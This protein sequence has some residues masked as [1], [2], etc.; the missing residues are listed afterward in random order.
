MAFSIRSTITAAMSRSVFRNAVWLFG[1]TVVTSGVGFL[2]WVLVARIAPQKSVGL[3]SAAISAMSLLANIGLLGLGNLMIG[4]LA[5]GRFQKGLVAASMAAAGGLSFILS[6]GYVLLRPLLGTRLGP[7]GHG[8]LGPLLFAAGTGVTCITYV[9]DSSAVGIDRGRVQFSR[10]VVFS[11]AKL[12]VVALGAAL[13]TG[14]LSPVIYGSWLVANLISL[15]AFLI[16]IR[17]AGVTPSLKPAFGALYQLRNSAFAHHWLNLSGQLPTMLITVVMSAVLVPRINATFYVTLIVI[18]SVGIIPMHFSTALFALPRGSMDR[19]AVEMRS[20]LRVSLALSGAGALVFLVGS[21]WILLLFGRGYLP[22]ETAMMVMGFY[23][24]PFTI[25]CHYAAVTRIRGQ[26]I[27]GSWV[28]M[29][30]GTLE[31]VLAYVGAKTDSITGAGVGFTSAITVEGLVLWP[32]VARAAK[33]PILGVPRWLWNE[34]RTSEGQPVSDTQKNLAAGSGDSAIRPG[35]AL[36]ERYWEQRGALGSSPLLRRLP[37][38]L[39]LI[40]TGLRVM[41]SRSHNELLE[42]TLTESPQGDLIVEMLTRKVGPIRMA[43][44]LM[45]VLHLPETIEEYLRGKKAERIR[46]N[47]RHADQIGVR[48]V[49]ELEAGTLLREQFGSA[50][51]VKDDP[52]VVRAA[53]APGAIAVLCRNEGGD[54][55]CIGTAVV[56]GV[57]SY[58]TMMK[59]IGESE[60]TGPA[61]W[62]THVELTRAL[63][64]A[65][66]K[67]LWAEGPLTI[68]PGLQ[69]FQRRLGYDC[70]RLRVVRIPAGDDVSPAE[71]IPPADITWPNDTAGPADAASA[72]GSD[73]PADAA[74]AP[75]G[76]APADAVPSTT[77]LAPGS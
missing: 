11:F 42:L 2:F 73:A 76:D 38:L 51:E 72:S 63:I 50:A 49:R 17:R 29:I 37:T 48:A 52:H 34:R 20:T 64:E 70:A 54:L 32:I 61:R 16:L 13:F 62:A 57:D 44:P 26:L 8:V 41:R 39:G 77:D 40:G 9:V 25:K 14:E 3:A 31:L 15:A 7:L 59:S 19:L 53:E 45:S 21:H 55:V 36:M 71:T 69:V 43:R 6:I 18:W 65:G 24:V 46:N 60:E 30:G 12:G 27:A 47:L 28:F 67:R 68:G 1:A 22:A 74:S 23:T 33:V 56:D 10:N 75:S 5:T 35:D 58:L 4:E 66:V